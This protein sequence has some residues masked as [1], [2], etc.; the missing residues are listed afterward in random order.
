MANWLKISLKVLAGIVVLILL[1]LV[2]VTLYISFNKAKVLAMVNTELRKNLDGTVV[3]GDMSPQF[4]KGFPNISLKLKNVL[5]R[6]KRFAQHHHTLLDAKDF[7]VSLN[8]GRLFKGV[9][10]I[11]HID[12]SNATIDLYTD[13]TGYSNTS[14]FKKKPKKTASTKGSSQAELEKF[15]LTNVGFKVDNEKAS[16]LFDFVVNNLHGTM[17][18]PDSGWRASFHMDVM[19]K[20]MAFNTKKGSFIKNKPVEGDLVANFNETTERI[21]VDADALDIG[22]DPFKINAIFETGKTADTFTFH[23]AAKQLLWQHASALLANNI[24]IK[25]NQ[26]NMSKPIGVTA[27][28]SGSFGGGDPF[29]YITAAVRNNKVTTPGGT[30]DDC[31]FDGIFTNNNIK[32]KDLSDEN[33]I[34]KLLKLT[35]SY[36]HLPFA[37]DTG[38]IINLT[39]PI[40]TGN[41]RSHFPVANLNY[42]LGNRVARFS[43]GTAD[44][45]LRY[46]ADIVDFQINKPVIKGSINFKNAD[47]NYLQSNLQLKNTSLSIN[48]VGNDLI[49]SH[50]RLQSGRSIVNMEGRVNNFMNLYYAAPE[51]ILLTWN[52]HSPQLYLGEFLGFLDGGASSTT[53]TK[54][55]NSGNVIDQ[56]STVLQK[57]RAAMHLDVANVHYNKFLATD[58]HA[59]LLTSADGVII[60]NVG[61]KN[62][63]GSL[64]LNGA[65]K[66]TAGINRLSLNTTI[67]N[68]NVHEFFY[69]FDNFGLKDLTYQNLKGILSAQTQI[70]AGINNKGTLLP[71]TIYGDINLNLKDG[72]LINF[73]P[74]LGVAKFAFPF[75]DLKNITIP[76]LD[77]QFVVKGDMIEIKPM[78]ISS[79]VLNIDVAGTYG[80]TRGTNIAM[81]VPLRNPKKD[82]TI[83]DEAELQRKRYKGIVLHILAKD[84]E[85]GK[86]K[87][88]WNK[89]R[90]DEAK[91]P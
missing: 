87:I 35:G 32:G 41:F 24:A 78:Q 33:S 15:S 64:R 39:K 36:Q 46:K 45:N 21:T 47:I 19:A 77:A 1:L 72:A 49:L 42:L 23:I 69:A 8:A 43:K 38:S 40:A 86:V 89:N 56:L 28:I 22:D 30:L 54:K 3:I 10:S 70:T 79:S 68:V 44:I 61:L 18:Y 55:G 9:V 83:V 5:I 50:I 20:S 6:D 2:G 7:D 81:D 85:T 17:A 13:S 71:K 29:L 48:I 25:L 53:S 75:R 14:L 52:I 80:L 16:K 4:F 27:I 88:G 31:S 12:I 82:T 73:K 60:K 65:I 11:N 57:G 90:K 74:L 59:D 84:D 76:K 34:I 91:Q 37:I 67:S 66:K 51:K 62:A 58:V 63:G 26:F